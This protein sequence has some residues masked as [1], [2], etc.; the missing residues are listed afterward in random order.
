MTD[1]VRLS[2]SNLHNFRA[3]VSCSDLTPRQ[4]ARRRDESRL[5]DIAGARALEPIFQSAVGIVRESAGLLYHIAEF[6]IAL[7][8]DPP[9][10][11]PKC[12]T[13]RTRPDAP[14]GANVIPF[15]NSKCRATGQCSKGIDHDRHQ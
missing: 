2:D 9:N 5:I 12:S 1:D 3:D 6:G 14:G 4:T 11:Q 13:G 8:S 10:S 7:V 15:P